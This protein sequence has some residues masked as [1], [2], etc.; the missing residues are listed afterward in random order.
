MSLRTLA[1]VSSWFA[2]LKGDD[3][4]DSSFTF[5]WDFSWKVIQSQTYNSEASSAMHEILV[6]IIFF[7]EIKFAEMDP[8][9][10]FSS[11]EKFSDGYYYCS[12]MPFQLNLT[13][14]EIPFL[15]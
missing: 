4:L 9:T 11:R 5:S 12:P 8:S 13:D 15:F 7:F 1:C 3:H 6:I 2:Q 14:H 10:C